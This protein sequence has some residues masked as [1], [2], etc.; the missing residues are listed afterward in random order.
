MVRRLK[1]FTAISAILL[2]VFI[3][4]LWSSETAWGAS[5]YFFDD[6]EQMTYSEMAEVNTY[7]TEKSEK[8]SFDIVGV[9]LYAGYDDE[10][11]MEFCDDFYDYGGFGYGSGKDG[12]IFAVDMKSRRMMLVTTGYGTTAIT[13]QYE[14]AIYDYVTDSLENE[15]LVDAFE[16]YADIVED[17]VLAARKGTSADTDSG[18]DMPSAETA[19][20]MGGISLAAGAGAGLFSSQRQ[21]SKLKTVKKKTQA[22]SYARRDSLVLTRREDRFLYSTVAVIHRPRQNNNPHGNSGHPGGG[23][24]MHMGSSGMPHG[25]GHGRGF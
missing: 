18:S 19:A 13:D 17:Y 1:Q 21:K 10:S 23:T 5:Q 7:L 11:L 16:K 25:G 20:G 3:A 6:S 15:E 4:F 12:V 14:E 9:L 24:S 22:N 8:L 2:M